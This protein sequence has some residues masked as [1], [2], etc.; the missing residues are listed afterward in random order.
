VYTPR[1]IIMGFI[2]TPYRKVEDGKIDMS[3]DVVYLSAEEEDEKIIAQANAPYDKDGKFLTGDPL[4]RGL[5]GISQLNPRRISV[6]WTLLL[7]R[8]YLLRLHLFL[9]WSTMMLTVH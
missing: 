1:L 3:G 5:K 4:K 2:E 9:S 8:L 7:T 6:I